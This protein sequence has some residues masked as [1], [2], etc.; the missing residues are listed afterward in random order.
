MI[1]PC[2][3]GPSQSEA[4]SFCRGLPAFDREAFQEIA[5]TMP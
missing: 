1:S 5:G 2:E 4:A 3:L